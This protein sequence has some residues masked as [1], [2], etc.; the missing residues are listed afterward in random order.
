MNAANDVTSGLTDIGLDVARARAEGLELSRSAARVR[1][2]R[3][4]FE[5][6]RSAEAT[7]GFEQIFARMLVRE[8]RRGLQ[9]GFF[10][11]GPG[12]DTYSA[13]LDEHLATELTRRDTLG[14]ERLMEDVRAAQVAGGRA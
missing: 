9:D 14:I 13:W 8:M 2:A 4:S 1:D 12:A 10:G 6:G 5:S 3:D 7:K 11:S